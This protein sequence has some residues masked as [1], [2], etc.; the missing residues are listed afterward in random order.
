[1]SAR[2]EKRKFPKTYVACVSLYKEDLEA[3]EFVKVL[4]VCVH[5]CWSRTK[6]LPA[7]TFL[8]CVS[9]CLISF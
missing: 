6:P 1:M 8:L 3:M 9:T 7:S 4:Y 2:L 5:V